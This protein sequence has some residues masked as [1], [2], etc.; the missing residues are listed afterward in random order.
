MIGDGWM[1]EKW[2]ETKLY[3]MEGNGMET[4]L[5]CAAKWNISTLL[6]EGL[7]LELD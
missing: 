7:N 5:E 6:P 1:V 2:M 3:G 4:R